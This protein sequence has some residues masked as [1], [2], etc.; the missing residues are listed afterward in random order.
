MTY[1][2]HGATGAQGSP[3]V[4]ALLARGLS[5]SGIARNPDHLPSGAISLAVDL[6]TPAALAAAYDGAEG[7]F[8]HLPL[9]SSEDAVA[10]ARNVLQAV[11][12]SRPSRVVVSASGDPLATENGASAVSILVSG[13][14]DLGVSHAV[15]VPRLFLE[16]LLLPPIL[17]GIRERGELAYALRDD[18]AVAWAS[19][20][21]VAAVVAELL[22]QPLTE[23]IVE[24][25]AMPALLGADLAAAFANAR[26]SEVRYQPVTPTQFGDSLVPVLGEPV[27]TGVAAFYTALAATP[28]YPI[29]EK[30]SAQRRLG[31]A[32]RPITD[33]LRDVGV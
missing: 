8:V 30:R 7:V 13:L 5:V 28:G 6:S 22:T 33:W 25:G 1:L 27:A 17:A 10:F 19:H 24:V 4:A 18:Y 31:I 11:D 3:V 29:D 9:V 20:D 26:G 15:V 16:N 32:P 2:V 12:R 23:G 14:A 21:D